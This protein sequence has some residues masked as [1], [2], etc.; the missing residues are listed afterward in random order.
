MTKI[1]SSFN[2]ESL[3]LKKV[4]K[5]DV[6]EGLDDSHLDCIK[7]RWT[8]LL[9][10]SKDRAILAYFSL[11]TA[12]Q[13]PDAWNEKESLHGIPDAHWDWPQKCAAAPATNRVVYGILNGDDVEAAMVLKF[14]I[15]SRLDGS[16]A[17]L[18]YID[19]VSTAPWNRPQ[20]QAPQRFSGLGK[21]MFGSAVTISDARGLE[22]RCGLHSLAPAEGFYRRL[23]M[24]DLG[25]DPAKDNLRYFELDANAA[26][27]L[28][29]G[30]EK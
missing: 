23:G 4:F 24:S 2:V 25:P 30:D 20:I 9:T 29:N 1:I 27:N 21:V 19:Y 7:S 26:R 10:A 15:P 6:V 22:G 12:N 3:E 14:G 28:I 18:I 13:T 11:P 17:P 5:L 8:P 16:G